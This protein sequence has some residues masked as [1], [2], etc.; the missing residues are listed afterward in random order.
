MFTIDEL[1]GVKGKERERERERKKERKKDIV[2][3][4]RERM[5]DGV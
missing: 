5:R 2:G 4:V 1:R 3:K